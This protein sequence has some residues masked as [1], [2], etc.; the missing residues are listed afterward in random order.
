MYLT[1]PRLVKYMMTTICHMHQ[2]SVDP[3]VCQNLRNALEQSGRSAYSVATSIGHAPNWLYRV[4]NGKSGILLPTLREVADELG[5]TVGSLVD[6]PR[7]VIDEGVAPGGLVVY[8]DSEAQSI[9]AIGNA[10]RRIGEATEAVNNRYSQMLSHIE[11]AKSGPL[12]DSLAQVSK[13][14]QV[15]TDYLLGLT[16][17]PTPTRPNMADAVLFFQDRD[18]PRPRK[19]LLAVKTIAE[20]APVVSH[21]RYLMGRTQADLG[22]LAMGDEV[23]QGVRDAAATAGMYHSKL[24]DREFPRIQVCALPDLL[25]GHGFDLPPLLREV[26]IVARV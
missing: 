24:L 11:A 4:L 3:V 5:V 20:E 7:S 9:R 10:S 26:E 25:S 21:L 14:L 6:P 1:V 8:E 15:S 22:L 23:H 12:V 13:L 17:D 18:P 2:S 16:N 19:I